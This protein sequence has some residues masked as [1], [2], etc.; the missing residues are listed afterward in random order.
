MT[1]TS[2]SNGAARR[3]G[4]GWLA[5]LVLAAQAS[6]SLSTAPADALRLEQPEPEPGSSALRVARTHYYG[7]PVVIEVPAVATAGASFTVAVTTYGGGCIAEDRTVVLV[8]GMTADVVPYQRV[9]R[10]RANEACTEELRITRRE[11]SVTFQAPGQA[12]VRM[13]GRAMPGDSLVVVERVVT[14]R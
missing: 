5:A 10:P 11:A 4:R 7:Q 6:C 9:Y 1:V 13:H 8:T 3:V 2:E 12:V 14:V